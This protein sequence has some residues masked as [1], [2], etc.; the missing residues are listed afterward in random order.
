MRRVAA[1]GVA[2][3]VVG[4]AA[5]VER[6]VALFL[7]FDGLVVTGV[8]AI[9]VLAGLRY[10]NA[11]RSTARRSATVD[12]P[13]RRHRS[14]VLGE[15]IEA[16]LESGG[17]VG[18]ARRVELRRRVRDLA[19][20]ALVARGTHDR[21]AARRA[22]ASGGWTDDPVAAGYL[23]DPEALPRRL[24]ARRLL[25]PRSTARACL[26]RSLDAIE[27]VRAT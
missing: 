25:R 19:V 12:P 17:R 3:V 1:V 10:A 27:E 20:D 13:E 4:L 8:G 24:R 5:L 23:A 26:A 22:V 6:T 2:A 7:P 18:T 14:T 11:A 9:A 15:P 16:A 21:R